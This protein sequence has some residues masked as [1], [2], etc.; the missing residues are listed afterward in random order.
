MSSKKKQTK[1]SFSDFQKSTITTSSSS[2]GG[3]WGASKPAATANKNKSAPS[4]KKQ[5]D[6]K[7]QPKQQQ[8]QKNVESPQT[9]STPIATPT[10]QQQQQKK[11]NQKTQNEVKSSES[12]TPTSTQ[13]AAK[14]SDK[15]KTDNKKKSGGDKKKKDK[16]ATP[17]NAVSDKVFD[18]NIELFFKLPSD[19][20]PIADYIKESLGTDAVDQPLINFFS[21][22]L[23]AQNNSVTRVPEDEI[24]RVLSTFLHETELSTSRD[25]AAQ[26]TKTM[27]QELYEKK[28]VQQYVADETKVKELTEAISLGRQFE[29]QQKQHAL[30]SEMATGTAIP[31]ASAVNY[32]EQ[33]DWEKKM[34]KQRAE[35]QAKR[36]SKERNEKMA[37]YEQYLKRRGLS[38]A[39]GIVKMHNA[40]QVK[41]TRDVVLNNISVA[42][43][44][45]ELLS[46]SDF[47][48]NCGHRYGLIGKNGVGKT[49]LLRHFVERDLPGIP[50]YLQILHIEQEVVGDETT[51]ID[52]VLKTDVE[53]I[54]LLAEEKKIL[55]SGSEDADERLTEIYHR[56]DEIDAHSAE[57]RAAAILNGLQFTSEMQ[58]MK[59][60]DFSGGWRMRIA[61]AR[62][63]FV[64]P[65]IL[66]LD[67]PTNHLDLAAV[68]WL[69]NYL[70][71]WKKTLVVVSHA[72][73]FLNNVVT[74]IIHFHEKKLHYYKGD[75]NTF[76]KAR[77]DSLKL[78]HKT[79]EAQEKQRKHIQQFID[80]FRYKTST[81]QMV[82]S[83]IKML[84]KMEF[85]AAVAED[86]TFSFAIPSPEPEAPPYLQSVDVT[87]GFSENKILFKKLN[88]NLDMDSRIALVGPNGAGKT[89]FLN[90]LCGD[91]KPLDGYT[92]LNRK[93]RI[94]R[95]TQ[96]HTDQLD[97][98]MTPLE[99]MQ[100]KYP[101]A[102]PQAIRGH[103]GGLGLSGTLATQPIYTLSG[104]QKSRVSFAE[105][106]YNK[107]HLLLMDEPTNHLDIDSVD[108]LIQALNE[109]RGGVLIIS[110]DE[111]L[112]KT[113]CDEI[114]VCAGGDLKKFE[115][116]F[117]D[118]KK[119]LVF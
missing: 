98:R 31:T 82:Q 78:Q 32:N 14:K 96:H 41:G 85:V 109:Y 69:E 79:F 111:H 75:Y 28:L 16:S 13:P 118:Y 59:T 22:V 52:A 49:T 8:Q 89:T 30:M 81:A 20:Q 94:A 7:Q 12:T 116:T 48:L 92:N 93:I 54:Q 87:F 119:T 63:L 36:D 83:R 21:S 77:S 114:W 101:K 107:P 115:G 23:Y 6:K 88:F 117:D 24:V 102:D 38:S 90:V 50:L 11:E 17:S 65:D 43:G 105:L 3:G 110:H 68:L 74:D 97:M 113:V 99:Y 103:L 44:N 34:A 62:A 58:T 2:S 71:K 55:E 70:T 40:D 15:K 29:E 18:E 47:I 45:Q 10:T 56:M 95:F 60:K 4:A 72:R 39:K 1:M 80:R 76:E 33:L 37:E 25:E 26:R 112:I 5:D 91:L 86:P 53:R 42:V 66:L 51:A 84:E 27:L 73:S 35:R 61:L 64:E 46:D 57:S 104:G 100:A 106:T 9:P 19:A 108:A 67:E